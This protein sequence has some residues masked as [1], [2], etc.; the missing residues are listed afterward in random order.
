[1]IEG[2]PSGAPLRKRSS[3][4]RRTHRRSF[5]ELDYRIVDVVSANDAHRPLDHG[6]GLIDAH[7]VPGCDATKLSARD[8]SYNHLDIQMGHGT[9]TDMDY[10]TTLRLFVY[11][12]FLRA[13]FM[14]SESEYSSSVPVERPRP[15]V[16]T[17]ISFLSTRGF[18]I[19][20][21]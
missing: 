7:A 15:R 13:F 16:D 2:A 18:K 5:H 4:F 6:Q 3:C 14:V 1:M 21:K 12:L 9:S 19:S 11:C 10:I 17:F 20:L 8:H